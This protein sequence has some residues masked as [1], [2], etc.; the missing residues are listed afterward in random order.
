M[1]RLAISTVLA[2]T[3]FSFVKGDGFFVSGWPVADTS[4]SC[5]SESEAVS[6]GVRSMTVVD[7]GSVLD[8]S[9]WTSAVSEG[10]GLSTYTPATVIVIR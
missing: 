1:N 7:A 10:R 9:A 8:T 6:T 5:V 3:V 4:C 2:L